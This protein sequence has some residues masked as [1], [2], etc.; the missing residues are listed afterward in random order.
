MELAQR[1]KNSTERAFHK[2]WSVLQGLRKDIM[3]M[4]D[5]KSRLKLQLDL[6]K[7]KQARERGSTA[8]E[9]E[10]GR[11]SGTAEG[12]IFF[13]EGLENIAVRKE[14]VNGELVKRGRDFVGVRG[15]RT[16]LVRQIGN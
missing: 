3:R 2:A 12:I 13:Q 9:E 15:Q 4:D 1:Y 8:G 14:Y 6:L 10:G 7:L 5:Q 11:T 16:I